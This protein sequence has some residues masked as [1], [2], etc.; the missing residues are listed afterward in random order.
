M[1][2]TIEDL[3]ADVLGC[4]LRRLDGQSL[5]VTS[6]ATAALQALATDPEMWRALCLAEWPSLALAGERRLLL[7]AT[8]PP[9]RLFADAPPFPSADNGCPGAGGRG[10]LVF[11]LSGLV[12]AVDVYYHRGAPLLSRVAETPTRHRRRG[13]SP[14]SSAWRPSTERGQRLPHGARAELA[15]R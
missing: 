7:L 5:A 9:Q 14:R 10:A 1:V 13:S 11:F 4:T 3:H 2:T 15:G 6:C 12:S 8:L